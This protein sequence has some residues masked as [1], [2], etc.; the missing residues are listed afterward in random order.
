MCLQALLRARCRQAKSLCD[1]WG[2]KSVETDWR[3]LMRAMILTWWISAAEQSAR[4]NRHRR[5]QQ[6][7]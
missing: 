4:R 1:R 6:G 2:Y 7:W 5:R 3:K